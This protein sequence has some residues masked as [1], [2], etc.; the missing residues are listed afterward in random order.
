MGEQRFE[1]ESRIRRGADFQRV[2]RRRARASDQ[3]IIVCGCENAL[4][5]PRLGLSVSRKVGNA[6]VRNRWKRLVREA[7][8]LDREHLPRGVDLVVIP[9]PGA[10]PELDRL[11][12][13]LGWLAA[14]VASRLAKDRR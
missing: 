11:R 7:F 13:S 2:Y 9:R 10:E 3:T 14:R 12:D 5:R 1:P 6:V 8:R 4:G